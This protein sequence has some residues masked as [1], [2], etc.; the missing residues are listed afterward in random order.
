MSEAI[1]LKNKTV[2]LIGASQGIGR[3][4]AFL[5]AKENPKKLILSSRTASSLEDLCR[6][7]G[8]DFVAYKSLDIALETDV[9][10]VAKEIKQQFGQVDILI[11]NSGIYE[12]T[13][14]DNFS[15]KEYERITKV[16]YLGALYATE[17]VLPDMLKESSGVIVAVSSIAGVRPIPGGGAYGAS[18]AALTYFYEA[19]RM[20]VQ[21][22]GVKIILVHPGFV[23]TRLTDKNTFTMPGLM[24]AKDAAT[25]IV[26]GIKKGKDE[27]SFPWWFVS[28]I[29]VLRLLPEPI[30]R[31]IVM[32]MN[33]ESAN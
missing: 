5:I 26:N 6:E 32:S 18:K 19:L 22:R 4:L 23:K 9:I 10:K 21:D 13:Y 17:Q 8:S 30:Y 24:T 2:W 12:I 11:I 15:A 29:R 33:K 3:E 14:V 7:I 27:I 28:L 16:N 1:E 31:K 20:Q 25:K